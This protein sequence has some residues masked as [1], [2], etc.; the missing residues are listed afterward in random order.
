VLIA[1]TF[2]TLRSAST[3]QETAVDTASIL[4][5][6]ARPGNS[7]R[8][9]HLR[10]VVVRVVTLLQAADQE[11]GQTQE[12][13]KSSIA[14]AASLLLAEIGHGEVILPRSD[15]TSPLLPWQVSRVREYIERNLSQ[16]IRVSDLSTLVFRTEAHFSRAFKRSFGLTPHAYLLR[17]RIELASQLMLESNTPLSEI[18]LTCGFNDQAHLCKRFREHT[19]ATP[20][21]WRRAQMP[22]YGALN[23]GCPASRATY[24]RPPG[25]LSGNPP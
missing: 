10:E 16:A 5:I 9:M 13:A 18:A 12:A 24:A 2:F 14:R 11:L 21:A 25:R 7:V 4:E 23:P 3:T 8:L 20:A 22:C 17:R 15:G 19:G 1:S 6:K